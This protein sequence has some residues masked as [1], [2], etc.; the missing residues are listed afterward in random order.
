MW[1]AG[2]SD[3]IWFDGLQKVRD[4]MTIDGALRTAPRYDV[5]DEAWADGLAA[6]R[7]ARAHRSRAPFLWL[8]AAAAAL[9]ALFIGV[10]RTADNG[11]VAVR[12]VV[13]APA[14]HRTP[15]S[16]SAGLAMQPGEP[17]VVMPEVVH[18]AE[19]DAQAAL[20]HRGLV[21]VTITVDAGTYAPGTVIASDP[22]ADAYVLPGTTIRLYVASGPV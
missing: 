22:P 21:V 13:V 7:A 15:S 17:P 10:S 14:L 12:R 19:V 5:D 3:D 11:D 6:V 16:T 1:P 4:E 8:G 18:L 2:V 9:A 20:A